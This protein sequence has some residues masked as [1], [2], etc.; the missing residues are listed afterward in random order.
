VPSFLVWGVFGFVA[1]WGE[2]DVGLGVGGGEGEDVENVDRDYI[3]SE[4]VDLGGGVGNAV[5][6]DAAAIG[7]FLAFL[8]GAFD[9]HT[10]EMSVVIDDEVVGGIVSPGLGEDEAEFNGAEGEAEFGPLS[11]EFGVLDV[12]VWH[13][14]SLSE[15]LYFWGDCR[16]C[17]SGA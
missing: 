11:A 3:G 17:G 14:D 10:E 7:V 8:V 6:V 15:K 5:V 16:G 13:G 12:G 4:E 9:L 2:K 1:V